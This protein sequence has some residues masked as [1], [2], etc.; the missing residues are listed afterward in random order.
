MATELFL[1]CVIPGKPFGTSGVPMM[2]WYCHPEADA[3]IVLSDAITV[4]R[5]RQ[6]AL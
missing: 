2:S 3:G 4:V 5:Y 1:G 6:R